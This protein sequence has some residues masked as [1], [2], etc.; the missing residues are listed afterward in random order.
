MRFAKRFKKDYAALAKQFNALQRTIAE[1][2][3]DG[4]PD[5]EGI[6]WPEPDDGDE[7][8]DPLFDSTRDY[9]E[10]VDRYKEHLNEPT[11]RRSRSK[12]RAAR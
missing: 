8:D 1:E 3:Q 6:E 2:L 4:A 11:E 5:V 10:Q 7:D 12:R 9:V